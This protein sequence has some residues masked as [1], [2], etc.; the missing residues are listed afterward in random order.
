MHFEAVPPKNAVRPT[1]HASECVAHR[2]SPIS[3]LKLLR[4]RPR[5][6]FDVA[7]LVARHALGIPGYAGR[8]PSVFEFSIGG[9]P[10]AA[11]VSYRVFDGQDLRRGAV[12]VEAAGAPMGPDKNEYFRA[13]FIDPMESGHRAQTQRFDPD[14]TRA[15]LPYLDVRLVLEQVLVFHFHWLVEKGS[16]R[17]VTSLATDPDFG[18][19]ID[20]TTGQCFSAETLAD[21]KETGRL[22]V[23]YSER[24]RTPQDCPLN[25]VT[26]PVDI[27][28]DD[29]K[30]L[31]W[32][33]TRGD[34]RACINLFDRQEGPLGSER[35]RPRRY[36][37][38]L[39]TGQVT[40]GSGDEA[41]NVGPI[42]G[43]ARLALRSLDP[44]PGVREVRRLVS[45]PE[46]PLRRTAVLLFGAERALDDVGLESLSPRAS[47]PAAA[48]HPALPSDD[49]LRGHRDPGLLRLDPELMR[50]L[51]VAKIAVRP[52]V[53]PLAL[54]RD[55]PVPGEV[56]IRGFVQQ[57]KRVPLATARL[58]DPHDEIPIAAAWSSTEN[59]AG[60][61]GAFAWPIPRSR[62]GLLGSAPPGGTA[63]LLGLLD[64]QLLWFAGRQMIDEESVERTGC[65]RFACWLRTRLP[66]WDLDD[67]QGQDDRDGS[68][69]LD[70]TQ[71]ALIT[72]M[73][74]VRHRDGG[75]AVVTIAESGSAE[76]KA[77]GLPRS[78]YG[79]GKK[80]LTLVAG[81]TRGRGR[82]LGTGRRFTFEITDE[83][84]NAIEACDPI[85]LAKALD[86]QDL[87]NALSLLPLAV[88]RLAGD[89]GSAIDVPAEMHF[90][91]V[92]PL[93]L[94]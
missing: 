58:S 27:T 84:N 26:D 49:D 82:L 9:R 63:A 77:L 15:L 21:M 46:Q 36:A 73:E 56:E 40:S 11:P 87:K 5:T 33:E 68:R 50:W 92:P 94:D 75:Y 51:H 10:F 41:S 14:V 42:G 55:V 83:L 31:L 3:E 91:P 64:S 7:R 53:H 59:G 89:S 88:R 44:G 28:W 17:S 30:H 43:A 69:R 86:S 37:V 48:V 78:P 47:L 22:E 85:G 72:N 90:P 2:A 34:S 67:V 4:D 6:F 39:E 62:I 12:V 71:G 81:D 74:F 38:D 13:V 66:H 79:V 24:Y 76:D 19:L 54:Y 61:A 80:R 70:Y 20:E 60:F 25:W 52:L 8:P 57:L 65:R 93:L 1:Q 18:L 16:A 23:R 35:L 32:P 45:D 29:A